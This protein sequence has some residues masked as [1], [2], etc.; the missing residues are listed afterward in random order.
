MMI[1][2]ANAQSSI[3]DEMV[4]GFKAEAVT[5]SL[6]L[7]TIRERLEADSYS[8][9]EQRMM[10][11]RQYLFNAVLTVYL[12]KLAAINTYGSDV[13]AT[14]NDP[15]ELVDLG[16]LPSWPGNPFNDWEP[17]QVFS[18]ADPFSPGDLVVELCPSSAYSSF[19]ETGAA[20]YSFN[21]YV[22]GADIIPEFD[23]N[24]WVLK[25]N[26]SW[27]SIPEGALFSQ[28][29]HM[30]SDEEDRQG[31]ARAAQENQGDSE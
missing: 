31:A 18:T 16:Y 23:A 17:M 20:P 27:S 4:Q 28:S 10:D 5:R 2:G 9:E 24:A 29:F 15:L 11:V 30:S 12:G 7:Q 8:S 21:I 6:E 3:E 25:A 1:S 26:K 14:N 19:P 13:L 22:Y